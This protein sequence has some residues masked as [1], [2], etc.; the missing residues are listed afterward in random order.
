MRIV[1]YDPSRRAEV[2]DLMGR[3]WDERPDE[4]ELEWFYERNPVRPASV[5]LGEDD[6][7]TVIATV[8]IAFLRMRIGGDELEVG[9]PLR[10]ATD[11]AQ[12]GK[13]VFGTLQAENE[14]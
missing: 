10:V 6:D 8:A 1:A 12:R 3:V 11:V 14:R 5:L 2:A 9:M 4:A 13:G 7:G